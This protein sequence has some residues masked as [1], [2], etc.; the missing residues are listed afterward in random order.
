MM[1]AAPRTKEPSLHDGQFLYQNADSVL[2][3]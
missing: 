1:A 2:S 3:T